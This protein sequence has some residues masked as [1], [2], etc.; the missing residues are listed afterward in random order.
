MIV[1]I[2]LWVLAMIAGLCWARWAV[3]LLSAL[4]VV[5]SIAVAP[6][7]VLQ[8]AGWFQL[9]AFGITPW[10]LAAQRLTHEAYLRRLQATEAFRVSRLQ[11][12]VRHLLDLQAKIRRTE[13]RIAQI[14]DVYHVTKETVRA[15]RIDELFAAALSV[16]PRLLDVQ[17]LRLIDLASSPAESPLVLRAR[18]TAEGRLAA[19]DT[20][21]LMPLEQAVLESRQAG[22]PVMIELSALGP[23]TGGITRVA[24]A[25]LFGEAGRIGMLI[26]DELPQEQLPA[27]KIVA[28]QIALQL[29]RIH[30]YQAIQASAITDSLTGVYVRRYVCELAAEELARSKRQG[31]R[32]AVLMADL[33]LFKAKNDMY[34]H[35]VGDVVLR[36][37]AASFRK[38]LREVDLL[39]RFGGE[40][41]CFLLIETDAQK[42]MAVAERLRRVVE[43]RPIRAYD[44]TLEQT[45]SIGVA[46]FPD[47]GQELDALIERADQALYAA[48]R[49]GRNRVVRWSA[50]KSQD[51]PGSR[52]SARQQ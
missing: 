4:A 46:C 3:T 45:V 41:F 43:A 27:L 29:S 9:V 5:G 7:N 14:T 12:A 6:S 17:G 18:R 24:A 47:D 20:N 22:E 31:L 35:L 11:Q 40:E 33:D 25:N 32:C 1:V 8:P 28:D 49:A 15:M 44:E 30:L 39:G 52:Q 48:K 13:A 34:G 36:E 23:S 19:E 26:A 37:V 2:G 50:S 10:L 51:A 42:A 21:H 38:S 16:I